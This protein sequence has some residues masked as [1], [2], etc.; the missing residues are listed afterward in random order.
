MKWVKSQI[1]KFTSNHAIMLGHYHIAR[2]ITYVNGHRVEKY[3]LS[4][5]SEYPHKSI[6]WFDSAD[7]AKSYAEKLM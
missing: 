5:C 4:D 3:L 1:G 6:K 2:F 7:D